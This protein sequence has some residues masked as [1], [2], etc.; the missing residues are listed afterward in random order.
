MVY[1][2]VLVI[3]AGCGDAPMLQAGG[4]SVA[5]RMVAAFQ[6]A[7]VDLIAVVTGPEDKKLEKQLAQPGLVFLHNDHPED[8]LVSRK[9]GLAYLQGKCGQIFLTPA[10]RPLISPETISQMLEVEG[11]VVVPVFQGEPGEPVLLTG[12]GI[13][14]FANREEIRLRAASL[15][16]NG[17]GVI[18]VSVDDPGVLLSAAESSAQ[19]DALADHDRKLTRPVLEFAVTRGRN[20]L[21]RKLMVLLYLIRETQSVRDAC[22]LMQISYSAAWNMLNRVE[23]DLGYPLVERIRGGT[24]GSGSELTKKG[25]A[26]MED[27]IARTAAQAQSAA[28]TGKARKLRTPEQ[29]P[30]AVK[31]AREQAA[32]AAE[33]R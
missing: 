18:C 31:K 20:L 29:E 21:D 27:R 32:S 23:D 1:T 14:W 3:A 10:D 22:S 7:G 9:L 15:R 11:E 19:T 4:I 13:E 25:K 33:P 5:Q 16:E 8:H 24:A 2:G 6:K 12:C 28:P 17:P 30:K 26:L